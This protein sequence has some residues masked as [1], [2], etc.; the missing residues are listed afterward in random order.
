MFKIKKLN[1]IFLNLITVERRGEVVRR[2]RAP[3][4]FHGIRRG[5][6]M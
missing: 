2:K 4:S 6:A 1:L 3:P 5:S